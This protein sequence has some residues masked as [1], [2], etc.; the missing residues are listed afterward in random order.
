M[1]RHPAVIIVLRS[2]GI[3]GCLT[4]PFHLQRR[5]KGIIM[6]VE[7]KGMNMTLL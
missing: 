5:A 1:R 4:T 6:D 2:C 7:S 3:V